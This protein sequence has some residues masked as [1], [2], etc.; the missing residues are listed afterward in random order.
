MNRPVTAA[1]LA[2]S[3]DGFIARPDGR[4]DFLDPFHGEDHGFEP[5]FAGVD[6]LLLGRATWEVV[7]GLGDWPY[8]RKRVAVLTHRPLPA[9]HGERALSGAPVDAL[10]RLAAEGVRRVYV[11]GGSVVSQVLA[12]GLLDELT[13]SVVPLVL[14]EGI[15][16]FQSPLPE[17]RLALAGC[18]PYRNGLVQ[19]RYRAA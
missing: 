15:R 4:Y 14:G 17:R 2:M 19:L 5:F 3:L 18:Q 16:L 6:A 8:G 13:V 10:A 12:A 9:R 7:A 1:F 11:D